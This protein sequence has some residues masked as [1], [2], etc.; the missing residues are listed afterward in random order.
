MG[1]LRNVLYLGDLF[2]KPYLTNLFIWGGGGGGGG[3]P[4]VES[5]CQTM[6]AEV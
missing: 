3:G 6:A 1:P 5:I 4:R 2:W